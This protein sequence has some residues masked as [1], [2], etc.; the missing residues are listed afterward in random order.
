[1]SNDYIFDVMG[2][3]E[4]YFD[5]IWEVRAFK[6]SE[7]ATLPSR[8]HMTDAG[9]DLYSAEDVFIPVGSTQLVKTNIAMEIPEGFVGKIEGRSSMNLKG[10][11][12][13]GGVIDSGYNGDLGVVLNN[14]SCKNDKDPNFDY[15]ELP[16]LTM[17]YKIKKGDKIAQ[18]LIYRIQTP[19][20]VE[21]KELWQSQRGNKGFGSSG[22]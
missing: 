16:S 3:D 18:L 2:P 20:V 21:T 10:I 19:E 17:G 15:H 12:T 1:M 13:S 9:L 22:K 5:D 14:F 7:N 11:M 6:L 4:F 8:T